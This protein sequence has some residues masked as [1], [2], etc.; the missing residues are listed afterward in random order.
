MQNERTLVVVADGGG[1]RVFLEKLP[2][3]RFDEVTE[4]SSLPHLG[5]AHSTSPGRVFDRMGDASHGVAHEP[6]HD[7]AER[8]FL[9]KVAKRLE[10]LVREQDAAQLMLMA[11]PKAMGVLRKHLPHAL[12][13]ILLAAEP[14][15][16][17]GQTLD[18]VHAAVRDLRR[19]SG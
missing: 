9:E 17:R 12:D 13:K 8:E 3:G 19:H 5:A 6:P 15:D 11:P 14:K 1:V 2:G 7:K 10:G 18:E 16:R 4:S